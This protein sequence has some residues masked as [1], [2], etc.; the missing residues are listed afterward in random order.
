[1]LFRSMFVPR[2]ESDAMSVDVE[3]RE[4]RGSKLE[5]GLEVESEE[6]RVWRERIESLRRRCFDT[7]GDSK[8]DT[9]PTSSFISS[10]LSYT[11]SKLGIGIGTGTGTSQSTSMP[12]NMQAYRA[13][14]GLGPSSSSMYTSAF[15]SDIDGDMYGL[16][17]GRRMTRSRVDVGTGEGVHRMNP[18]VGDRSSRV[19]ALYSREVGSSG[20]SLNSHLR[21]DETRQGIYPNR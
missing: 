10:T 13:S 7:T 15:S 19:N 20:S 4:S 2:N 9:N 18:I 21:V 6:M 8:Q 11:D 12:F 14:L 16:E 5:T 1:M 17:R 3:G